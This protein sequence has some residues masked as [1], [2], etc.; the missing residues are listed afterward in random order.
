M[1]TLRE[2]LSFLD[3]QTEEAFSIEKLK[4]LTTFREILIYLER[5]FGNPVSDGSSR[6]IWVVSN[7]LIVKVVKLKSNVDQN[8]TEIK[9]AKCLGPR[10]SVI[11]H[12]YDHVNHLWLLEEKLES[13]TPKEYVDYFNKKLGTNFINE[14][15]FNT[16]FSLITQNRDVLQ[17]E[18]TIMKKLLE[19]NKWF[20]EFS[21]A[22]LDCQVQSWDF[23]SMNW[24]KRASTGELVLLD[25]GY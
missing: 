21:K 6:K 12:D 2:F 19:T 17:N 10:F 15:S 25:L 7:E 4:T 8:I 18:K 13:V 24:G 9:N 5:N 16:L 14:W 11:I 22:I 20:Q 23:K 1:K 3:E